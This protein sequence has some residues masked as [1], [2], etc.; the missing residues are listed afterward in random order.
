MCLV[1]VSIL[2]GSYRIVPKISPKRDLKEMTASVESSGRYFKASGIAGET[3]VVTG[4]SKQ[5]YER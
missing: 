4:G 5:S 1:I 2:K 3:N